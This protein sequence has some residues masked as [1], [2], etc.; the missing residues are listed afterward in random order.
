MTRRVVE[1]FRAGRVGS[2]GLSNLVGVTTVSADASVLNE[3]SGKAFR[4][5]AAMTLTLPAATSSGWSLMV[6]ADGGDVTVSAPMLVDGAASVLLQDGNSLF[7]FSDGTTMFARYYA[8]APYTPL[9]TFDGTNITGTLANGGQ[10]AIFDSQGDRLFATFDQGASTIKYQD[11]DR[12]DVTALGV[13]L[14]GEVDISAGLSVAGLLEAPG[15]VQQPVMMVYHE[16]PAGTAGGTCTQNT[17]NL[18]PLTTVGHNN[19]VGASLAANQITLPAG[20]YEFEAISSGYRINHFTTRLYDAT[21]AAV[22]ADVR[23]M[24]SRARTDGGSGDGKSSLSGQFTLG[25]ES[26]LQVEQ[27]STDTYAGSGMGVTHSLAAEIHCSVKITK[28]G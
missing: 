3:D 26:V 17:W 6:D 20:T 21:A 18:R 16:E 25:V 5:T 24:T 7:V 1:V 10:F 27:N 19:I 14:V 28:V 2:D 13:S 4:C 23:G 9:W 15:G 12:I 11:Q 8:R 22:V